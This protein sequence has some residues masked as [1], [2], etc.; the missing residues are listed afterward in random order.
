MKA[1]ALWHVENGYEYRWRTLLQFGHSWKVIGSIYMK[2]PGSAFPNNTPP[3]KYH[4]DIE[5]IFNKAKDSALK[6]GKKWYLANTLNAPGNHFHHPKYIYLQFPQC[7][8]R[9]RGRER[10]LPRHDL[11]PVAQ[12]PRKV[13]CMATFCFFLVY[14]EQKN[15]K[16]GSNVCFSL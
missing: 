14:T 5:A 8:H 1:Y 7:G 4:P 10:S 2:N 6:Q 12:I 13:V 9:R 15:L 16:T 3:K 11:T